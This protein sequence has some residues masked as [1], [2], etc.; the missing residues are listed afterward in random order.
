MG[1]T[2][3]QNQR[4]KDWI[5]KVSGKPDLCLSEQM[6]IIEKHETIASKADMF[7]H[8]MNIFQNELPRIN[9]AMELIDRLSISKESI[10]YL[11]GRKELMEWIIENFQVTD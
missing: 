5:G 2:K 8:M 9:D 3:E 7:D 10:D 11:T 4:L 1:K 6:K